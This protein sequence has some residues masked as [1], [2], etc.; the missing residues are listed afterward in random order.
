MKVKIIQILLDKYIC[1][2]ENNEIITCIKNGNMKKKKIY[3]GDN[4]KVIISSNTYIIIEILDRMNFMIRPPVANID[5]MVLC[6]S[7][8]NPEPDYILLDK[9]IVLCLSKNIKPIICIT[10]T[11]LDENDNVFNYINNVYGKFYDIVN[12]NALLNKGIDKIRSLLHDKTSAFSGNSG[13]GKSSIVN[14]LNQND[15]L[16]I[17]EIGA[18]SNKGKHTTKEVRLFNI[19]NNTFILDTPGFSSYELFD[20]EYKKLSKYFK[21]FNDSSC[22]YLDCSHTNEK[23]DVCDIKSKVSNKIIDESLYERYIYI[24]NELYKKDKIKYK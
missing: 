12:V 21:Q 6:I 1:V 18:K 19:E 15:K 9:Q 8:K 3:V 24:Y 23:N 2:N 7:A 17:G 16:E 13:V 10:K 4:A 11:D 20:I 5:I 14:L 22:K